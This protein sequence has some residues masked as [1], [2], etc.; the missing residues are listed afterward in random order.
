LNHNLNDLIHQV[1]GYFLLILKQKNM[2]TTTEKESGTKGAKSSD[3]K[4]DTK[5]TA[6][7]STTKSSD[8]KKSTTAKK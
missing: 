2:K 7:K 4:T 5:G 3:K 8:N 6:S 1:T